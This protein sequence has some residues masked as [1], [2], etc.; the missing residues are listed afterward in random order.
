MRSLIDPV[1]A[2]L[3]R[4][5]RHLAAFAAVAALPLFADPVRI[6]IED[7]DTVRLQAQGQT[8]TIELTLSR[9]PASNAEAKLT[10]ANSDN[11]VFWSVP[12]QRRGNAWTAALDRAG[13]EAVISTGRLVAEFPGAA[14]NNELLQLVVPTDRVTPLIEAAAAIV[15]N[16]PLFF[17]P[18][19]P[20]ERPEVP[21]TDVERVRAESFAM[22]ARQWERELTAHLHEYQAAVSR[23]H[24][25]FLDLRT[26]GRLPWPADVVNRLEEQ[27]KR[28]ASQ[29]QD[30]AKQVEEWRSTAQSFVQ[31]WNQAHSGDAPLEISFA[32]PNAKS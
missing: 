16:E 14:P 5:L 13:L 32:D 21:S 7:N 9:A 12:M 2:P 1:P 23:A 25:F 24:A 4:T 26:A 11:F 8:G 29:V 19:T 15:G 17:Q 27:Y 31:Q 3:L 20:P 30:V 22:V 18:P 6:P 10:A 28:L